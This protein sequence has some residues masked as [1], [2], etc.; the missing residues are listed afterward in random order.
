MEEYWEEKT[1]SL[2]IFGVQFNHGTRSQTYHFAIFRDV[3]ELNQD[4]DQGQE[5]A[6]AKCYP[7]TL[8]T[9]T[10]KTYISI[11]SWFSPEERHKE[12]I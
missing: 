12:G 5:Q 4:H 9:A 6:M 7:M 10:H 11:C 8:M 2:V 3:V 1:I